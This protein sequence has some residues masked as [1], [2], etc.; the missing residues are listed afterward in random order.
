MINEE[1]RSP[2]GEEEDDLMAEEAETVPVERARAMTNAD[3]NELLDPAAQREDAGLEPF[4]ADLAQELTWRVLRP[5]ISRY[6]PKLTK[7]L[8]MAPEEALQQMTQE[9]WHLLL[10]SPPRKK[11]TGETP[12]AD[13]T[14][15]SG[16]EEPPSLKP[17]QPRWR[18]AREAQPCPAVYFRRIAK[19]RLVFRV[20]AV[21]AGLRTEDAHIA[22]ADLL[23]YVRHRFA[24][25]KPPGV[26]W[27]WTPPGWLLKAEAELDRAGNAPRR[28]L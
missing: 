27:D 7:S 13:E 2:V 21:G 6:L 25:W 28:R 26:I 10:E 19:V 23:D 1:P 3:L 17:G 20:A 11:A 9:L 16:E 22:D 8:R 24:A 12:E 5:T 15:F 14:A 18:Q 4:D